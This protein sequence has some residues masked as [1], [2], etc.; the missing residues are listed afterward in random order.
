MPGTPVP[1]SGPLLDR[2]LRLSRR[3]KI[4]WSSRTVPSGGRASWCN[5][6]P[7]AAAAVDRRDPGARA[8]LSLATTS[9]AAARESEM[10]VVLA[11]VLALLASAAAAEPTQ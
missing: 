6:A 1:V 4:L 3:A 7:P 8:S 2:L 5:E 10:R 11:A 9:G